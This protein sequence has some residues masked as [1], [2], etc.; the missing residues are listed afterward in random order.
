MFFLF[1]LTCSIVFSCLYMYVLVRKHG[2]LVDGEYPLFILPMLAFVMGPP[3]SLLMF[4]HWLFA[5]A[6]RHARRAYE[7]KK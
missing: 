6:H 1:Y 5:A 3:A 4:A 2:T 7:R